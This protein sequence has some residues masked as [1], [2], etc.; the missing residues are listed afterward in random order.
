MSAIA[1]KFFTNELLA[2]ATLTAYTFSR[3]GKLN[4]LTTCKLALA[5]NT[6]SIRTNA[7]T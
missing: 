4:G 3:L 5:N 7:S 6:I 2:Y 1:F